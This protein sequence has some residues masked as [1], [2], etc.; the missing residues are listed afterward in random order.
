MKWRLMNTGFRRGKFNME[1]D[2]YLA[3][4]LLKGQGVPT[5]RFFGWKPWAISLGFHQREDDIDLEKCGN[6]GIDVVKRPTG[7]RSILHAEELTYSV[8][9][10]SEGRTVMETYEYI[11]RALVA[12]LHYLGVNAELAVGPLKFSETYRSDIAIPCFASASKFE[13]Q[14]GGKKIAGSA[15]RRYGSS[16]DRSHDVVLQHGSVLLGPHHRALAE[17]ISPPRSEMREIIRYTL[18][19]KTT[20]VETVLG[21]HVPFDEVADAMRQGFEDAWGIRF[22]EEHSSMDDQVLSSSLIQKISHNIHC[23]QHHGRR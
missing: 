1:F 2:A 17:Y 16:Y 19:Q 18:E 11:S 4:R 7:G 3:Q 15:Q 14:C 6:D 12:G 5:V 22:A 9:M 10:Y 21:R 20:E 13:V 23:T 8:V